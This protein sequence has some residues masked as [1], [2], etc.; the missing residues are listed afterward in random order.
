MEDFLGRS[1]LIWLLVTGLV[2]LV[3]KMPRR[4]TTRELTVWWGFVLLITVLIIGAMR[5][6]A[7]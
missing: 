7:L 6:F 4:G 1:H 3:V 5:D 2:W